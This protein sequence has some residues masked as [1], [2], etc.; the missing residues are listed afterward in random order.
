[1]LFTPPTAMA[2]SLHCLLPFSFHGLPQFYLLCSNISKNCF[3]LLFPKTSY[4][5]PLPLPFLKGKNPNPPQ[6]LHLFTDWADLVKFS[7][8]LKKFCCPT[9][10]AGL[11]LP[12]RQVTSKFKNHSYMDSNKIVLGCM[13][14]YSANVHCDKRRHM[15]GA[16]INRSEGQNAPKKFINCINHKIKE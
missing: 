12:Y 1:M 13:S 6:F 2:I 14:K 5:G 3:D 16:I 8:P 10:S 9:L 4:E 15:I 7:S 11:V